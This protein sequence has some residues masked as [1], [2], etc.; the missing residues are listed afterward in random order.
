MK[1]TNDDGTETIHE[2]AENYADFRNLKSNGNN[3]ATANSLSKKQDIIPGLNVEEKN[4]DSQC[5]KFTNDDGTETYV[6]ISNKGIEAKNFINSDGIKIKGLN[7]VTVDKTENGDYKTITD[8]INN[9]NDGDI[10]F[11]M[12]G[13]YEEHIDMYNKKRH[14]IGISKDE[15]RVVTHD[16]L[17]S[18]N[19]CNAN[20]GI[21]ENMSFIAMIDK[22]PDN[23]YELEGINRAT[24]GI[25]C[26]A[27]YI[28]SDRHELII[29]NCR[30]VS[31]A[32]AGI[33]IGLR[34][35]QTI[36][37]ENC[38]LISY[39]DGDGGFLMHNDDFYPNSNGGMIRV[40]N[41]I[42]KGTT[43]AI[44]ISSLNNNAL[45]E[46]EFINNTCYV[47]K[48]GVKSIDN[49]VPTSVNNRWGNDISNSILSHNNNINLLN[50]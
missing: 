48:D 27:R 40:I 31:Y 21:I 41:C 23:Y 26:D 15:V 34:Y 5:V 38:E 30:C 4:D 35:N 43:K 44:S 24:Y 45:C 32:H 37:I 16:G 20:V 39:K 9:T 50:F 14:L 46:L 36:T 8:A 33:G 13:E 10:I 29:R 12:K 17:R 3:V 2:I 42:I 47:E 18:N 6:K 7:I 19:P 49:I 11:V 1:F 28:S 25:H 22:I